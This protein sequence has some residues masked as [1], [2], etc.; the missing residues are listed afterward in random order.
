M[1][2]SLQATI[3][4]AIS[5]RII[6]EYMY[7]KKSPRTDLSK[8]TQKS[9]INLNWKNITWIYFLNSIFIIQI[10]YGRC[11]C[12]CADSE[13]VDKLSRPCSLIWQL[14]SDCLL[15]RP[16]NPVLKVSTHCCSSQIRLCRCSF[17]SGATLSA[18]GILPG[19]VRV[20]SSKTQSYNSTSEQTFQSISFLLI[21]YFHCC[22]NTNMPYMSR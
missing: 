5:Q 1:W 11:S 7:I 2:Y 21:I 15:E 13:A 22:T 19:T 18:Y 3:H 10:C 8:H 14:H 4:S 9:E 6:E 12:V 16:C 17:W 20:K